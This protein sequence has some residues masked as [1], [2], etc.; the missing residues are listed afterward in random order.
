MIDW[1]QEEGALRRFVSH[2]LAAELA[3][4]HPG[5]PPSLPAGAWP[6]DLRLDERGLGLDSLDRMQLASAL[7]E[8]LDLDLPR[9][10]AARLAHTGFG[11][12]LAAC[13]AGLAGRGVLR[14][15]TSGSTGAARTCCHRLTGLEEEARFLAS[16]FSDRVRVLATVPAHHIYGFLFTVLL[17]RALGDRPVEDLATPVELPSLW[18]A[19]D[20]VVGFPDFWRAAVR[21]GRVAPTGVMG[22]TS[23]APCPSELALGVAGLGIGLTEIFGSS[24]TGGLGWR[25]DPRSPFRWFPWW[26]PQGE[27]RVVRRLPGGESVC[28]PLPDRL[29]AAGDG[30]FR[31][32]GRRDAQVQVGGVNVSPA[33]VR[34]CLLQHPWVADAAVRPMRPQEGGRLKA[35]VV[36]HPEAP[37][38]EALREGLLRWIEALLPPPERPRALRFGPSLPA[39]AMGKAADW[40]A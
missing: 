31:P 4:L 38:P 11:D 40:D 29:T 32:S 30:L 35:F 19:G 24:E 25:G 33:R 14:F 16:L 6:D 5:A 17:P 37:P 10:E 13:R 15:R 34:A 36:P 3:A 12:W 18:R 23:T 1:W 26:R 7:A 9:R 28:A 39:G 8:A 27:D 22:C 20:L 21:Q 2:L